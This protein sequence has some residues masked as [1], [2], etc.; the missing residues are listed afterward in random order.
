MSRMILTKE[1]PTPEPSL[2]S[3]PPCH[4]R[5]YLKRL[6]PFASRKTCEPPAVTLGTPTIVRYKPQFN[7]S[8]NCVK[9]DRLTPPETPLYASRVFMSAILR[10][11]R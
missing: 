10:V 8:P 3:I 1:M 2:I 7:F 9:A 6:N 4:R 5:P 11:V